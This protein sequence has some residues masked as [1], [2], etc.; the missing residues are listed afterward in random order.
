VGGGGLVL[1]DE[2]LHA[3]SNIRVAT[4]AAIAPPKSLQARSRPVDS[5]AMDATRLYPEVPA[6]PG[7][8]D[9]EARVTELERIVA[10][11]A[12]LRNERLIDTRPVRRDPPDPVALTAALHPRGLRRRRKAPRSSADGTLAARIVLFDNTRR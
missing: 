11:L 6:V 8:P 7:Q 2:L 3:G 12:T 9:L 5:M 4:V 1:D 10:T